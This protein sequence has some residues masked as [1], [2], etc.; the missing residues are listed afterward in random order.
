LKQHIAIPGAALG[1]LSLVGALGFIGPAWRANKRVETEI[2]AMRAELAKPSD[3]PEI[4]TGLANRLHE[5]QTKS[6]ERMV[7]IPET[8]DV[9]GLMTR[10]SAVLN[11]LG[12]V[13]REVTTGAET[14]VDETASLPMSVTLR[15][16]FNPIFE[17]IREIEHLP[18][19]VRI[20]RLRLAYESRGQSDQFNSQEIRADL[21]I[22]V[23]FG[24]KN[25]PIEE[26]ADAS[27]EGIDE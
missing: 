20:Q 6:R 15:G 4:I 21:L 14:A 12:L 18:R 2:L 25:E 11:R 27:H 22:D 7:P 24:A 8:S 26:V 23:F 9:A 10:L 16:G 13:Q 19:L 17:A 5:L 3:S 1:L